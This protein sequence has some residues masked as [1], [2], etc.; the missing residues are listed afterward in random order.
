MVIEMV[1]S[2]LWLVISGSSGLTSD[3]SLTN[4]FAT[5]SLFLCA[6]IRR[7]VHPVSSIAMR[8][9]RESQQAHEP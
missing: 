3:L 5:S 8:L 1:A 6:K 9:P 2:Q 4:S 7:I